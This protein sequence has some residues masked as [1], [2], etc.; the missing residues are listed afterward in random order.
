MKMKEKFGKICF[1]GW[2]FAALMVVYNELMLHTWITEEFH[3]GRLIAVI[4]FAYAVYLLKKLP[5]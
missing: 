1:P 5:K 2:L 4:A 3:A